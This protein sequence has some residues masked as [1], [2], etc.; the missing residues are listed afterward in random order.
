MQ[1]DILERRLSE[2]HVEPLM[3]LIALWRARGLDVPNVDP[4]DGG[5]FAKV[6]FLLESPGPQVVRSGFISRE[7]RDDS[8]RNMSKAL[9]EAGF[10]RAETLLWNVVPYCVS[11]SDRNRNASLAQIRMAAPDTNA[12]IDLLAELRAVVLCGRRAQYAE[13]YLSIRVRTFRTYHPGARAYRR[14]EYRKHLH[15]TLAAVRAYISN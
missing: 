6:L 8:A 12:F 14:Q 2:P 4:N 1:T 11:S 9:N 15:D 5:V 13:S 10:T 3:A 7:N